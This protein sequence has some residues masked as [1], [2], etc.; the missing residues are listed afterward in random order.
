MAKERAGI[1]AIF[2]DL[3]DTLCAYWEASKIGLREAFLKHGPPDISPEQMMESW[4]G[5]FREFS[6]TLK[7]SGWYEGYCVSGEPTRTEQMRLTLER[8]GIDDHKMASKLSESY[9]RERN[10][11]LRLFPETEEVLE[12]LHRH[13]PL[14]LIT[15]GPADIQ[16]EEIETLG[17]GLYFDHILIEGEMGEGKPLPSVFER[18]ADLVGASGEQMLFVGNSY[19][20]DVRPALDA[21][22]HA[23]WVRR[24]SD[25][26]PSTSTAGSKP[27]ELPPGAPKPDSTVGTLREVLA[28]LAAKP[29]LGMA[30][31]PRW[32]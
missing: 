14:G 16:R 22:W 17:I 13:Y 1:K 9:R 23:I 2:F 18:A 29:S 4:A 11:A 28:Y 7:Q 30:Q 20:H 8:I 3:D 15:N 31:S 19:K 21:G 24:P 12:A 27:E 32:R 5:A 10:R 26:P 25:V 6:P